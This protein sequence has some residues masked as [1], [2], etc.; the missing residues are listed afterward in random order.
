MAKSETLYAYS[1]A[2]LYTRA[3]TWT[4]ATN[5]DAGA[6]NATGSMAG[7]VGIIVGEGANKSDVVITTYYGDAIPGDQL[8]PGVLY[9]IAVSKI[10]RTNTASNTKK[11]YVL[12]TG[13]PQAKY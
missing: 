9:P 12:Y 1:N 13:S 10:H 3:E 4:S 8:T 11:I 2:G 5:G 6:F 7:S